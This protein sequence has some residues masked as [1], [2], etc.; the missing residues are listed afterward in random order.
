M[1]KPYLKKYKKIGS[2]IVWIVDG[3][4]VREK[5]NKEFSNFGQHYHFKF[6]PEKEFWIDKEH[7][8]GEAIFYIDHLLVEH[9]LIKKGKSYYSAI[10]RADKKEK[11]E[12]AILSIK[13]K[14]LFIPKTNK[15]KETIIKRI[16]TR[17]LDH[18]KKLNIW[19]VKGEIVRDIFFIDFT[20]GG[21]DKVYP[22]VPK[23]EIWL[24][25][26]L[27]LKERNFVLLH[28]LHERY[29]MTS[30]WSYVKAHAEANKFEFTA[31]EK[32]KLTKQMITKELKRQK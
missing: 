18:H 1:K 13:K 22:F 14:K 23:N 25:D 26:D 24:D 20:E 9:R 7:D 8:P 28:E 5:I 21:H 19:I 30:S 27:I 10:D 6:I 16:H 11:R 15:E 12:R 2:I 17:L 31:R 4:Y 32:P 29:R 3:E